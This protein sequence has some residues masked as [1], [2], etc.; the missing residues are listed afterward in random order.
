MI[1]EGNRTKLWWN[2]QFVHQEFHIRSLGDW[3]WGSKLRN[4]R[5][6]NGII[7]LFK[8]IINF[9]NLYFKLFT[10]RNM[11]CF[12]NVK[13]QRSWKRLCFPPVFSLVSCSVYFFDP[14]DGGDIF[15]R[16]VSWQRTTRRYIPEDRSR[17]LLRFEVIAVVTTYAIWRR[18][19][20]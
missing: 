5:L 18:V 2:L 13:L 14:E 8:W 10:L 1:R 20:W 17:I 11:G 6:S 4:Q 16:N 15:L 3:T 19:V 9:L 7:P 12:L